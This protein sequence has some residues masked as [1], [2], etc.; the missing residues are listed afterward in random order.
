[1]KVKNCPSV[2]RSDKVWNRNSRLGSSVRNFLKRLAVARPT[3]QVLRWVNKDLITVL[4]YHGLTS[5]LSSQGLRNYDGKHIS[6]DMFERQMRYISQNSTVYPLEKISE[7]LNQGTPCGPH[8]VVITFDDGYKSNYDL[9]FPILKHYGLTATFFVT[10]GFIGSDHLL[11]VDQLEIAFEQT[12]LQNIAIE[13]NSVLPLTI[14]SDCLVA[15]KQAKDYLKNMRDNKKRRMI[16]EMLKRLGFKR[17]SVHDSHYDY[18]PMSWENISEMASSGMSIGSHTVTHAILTRCN[19]V[20]LDDEIT[21]SKNMIQDRIQRECTLFCYPNGQ[22]GDFDNC[23]LEKLRQTEYK[24]AVLLFGGYNTIETDPFQLRRFAV[25]A[26]NTL[27]DFKYL[28]TGCQGRILCG[29]EA[30]YRKSPFSR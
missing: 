22:K 10:T 30:R 9:A 20:E 4:C 15:L 28:L 14:V 18:Q 16:K 24:C 7:C 6:V 8:G 23:T 17:L 21:R 2:D 19:E 12:R 13:S 25:G 26:G 29:R 27:Q 5:D 3:G 11:W 1:M